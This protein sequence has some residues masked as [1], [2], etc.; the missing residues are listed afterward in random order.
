VSITSFLHA[1]Q[2]SPVDTAPIPR[3]GPC[4]CP[5]LT[6]RALRRRS[7]LSSASP[8][9]PSLSP[10]PVTGSSAS[11]LNGTPPTGASPSW[12]RAGRGQHR[13]GHRATVRRSPSDASR[14]RRRKAGRG[15]RRRR[16]RARPEQRPR[17]PVRRRLPRR[18]RRPPRRAGRGRRHG[19]RVSAG[20]EFVI[21][22]TRRP[23]SGCSP[24]ATTSATCTSSR[25]S[26]SP[27]SSDCV[28]QASAKRRAVR[29][30]RERRPATY[31]LWPSRST[32]ARRNPYRAR[33][34]QTRHPPW[35]LHLGTADWED[36][37]D[38]SA[39][40]PNAP[41]PTS[42]APP[43]RATRVHMA[44]RRLGTRPTAGESWPPN[45]AHTH[46]PRT[47][48]PGARPQP[49][50]FA[51]AATATRLRCH[52]RATEDVIDP[53]YH[54]AWQLLSPPGRL[55][56]E[57]RP[58]RPLH[59]RANRPGLQKGHRDAA[60]MVVSSTNSRTRTSTARVLLGHAAPSS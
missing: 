15:R 8:G 1:G 20:D 24:A 49:T 38:G 5:G 56:A 22:T 32:T 3:P 26:A 40:P 6:D 57:H 18:H 59:G 13:P 53:L 23:R 25:C 48:R 34:D 14:R 37:L 21:I 42:T 46:Q 39:A 41:A 60:R 36:V 58:V 16:R 52:P 7:L 54:R 35:A 50:S 47:L 43:A 55:T 9:W 10:W 51:A 29:A 44:R 12:S 28:R 30:H 33:L 2:A 17:P 27:C 11:A 31:R 45:S 19:R 4:P